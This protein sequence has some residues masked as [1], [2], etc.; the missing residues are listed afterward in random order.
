MLLHLLIDL[1]TFTLFIVSFPP[2]SQ[3]SS[4]YGM[5]SLPPLEPLLAEASNRI[6]VGRAII[7]RLQIPT[8]LGRQ[9]ALHTLAQGARLDS[10]NAYW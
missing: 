7:W 5:T 2:Y 6:L 8:H 1:V 9:R 3:R 10:F 4:S